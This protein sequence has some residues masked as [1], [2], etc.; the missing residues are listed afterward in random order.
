MHNRAVT[1]I[2]ADLVELELIQIFLPVGRAYKPKS[3]VVPLTRKARLFSV[4]GGI[5]FI[6]CLQ[7]GQESPNTSVAAVPGQYCGSKIDW[8][9]STV[10]PLCT[11]HVKREPGCETSGP[12]GLRQG[13]G[14]IADIEFMVQ[15]QVVNN[16]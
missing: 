16:V 9:D 2:Y 5:E 8:F 12:S 10:R 4:F 1:N 6:E 11:W 15:Y 7:N 13:A 14:G 3:S